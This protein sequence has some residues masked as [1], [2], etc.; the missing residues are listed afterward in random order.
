ML[1]FD[2]VNEYIQMA[3]SLLKDD[4]DP[5]AALIHREEMLLKKAIVE[6]KR[7]SKEMAKRMILSRK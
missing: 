7:D 6:Y 1:I 3:R 5:L 2:K 4:S